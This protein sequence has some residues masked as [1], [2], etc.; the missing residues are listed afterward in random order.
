MRSAEVVQLDQRLA[1]RVAIITGAASGIGSA[2]ARLFAEQGAQVEAVDLDGAGLDDLRQGG[3]TAYPIG[4][5]RVDVTDRA[6]GERVVGDVLERYGR[7][8]I[9]CNNAGIIQRATVLELDEKDWDRHLAVNVKS[10]FIWSRAALP[11]MIH[12]GSGVILNTGSGWGL[13]GGSRAASYCASK[14]AVVQLTR[15]MAIDHG[16]QGI[17]VNCICPGDTDTPLLHEEANQIGTAKEIFLTQA[18]QRPLGRVGAAEE[19][20]QAALFLV[21]DEASFVTGTTLVVDGG[22]LAGT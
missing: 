10:V 5:H 3:G 21:S 17:R 18:A 4:S 9:L 13:T 11:P 6:A 14:G 20:A 2:M 22:G 15:A 8:D 19:I 7:L 16:P 1:G 12:Q